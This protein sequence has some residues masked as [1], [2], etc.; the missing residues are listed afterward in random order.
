VVLVAALSAVGLVVGAGPAGAAGG[1]GPGGGGA[2]GNGGA[3]TA[4]P[5]VG[6]LA[7]F[8]EPTLPD[9]RFS[10]APTGIH[11]FTELGFLQHATVDG[12]DCPGTPPAAFGGTAVIDNI[13][14]TVPCNMTVQMPA[15][16][17]T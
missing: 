9:P 7:P 17:L 12:K 1:P 15:N 16:T 10:V 2:N 8:V 5:V 3:G 6:A 13:T 4:K 14:I 11:G